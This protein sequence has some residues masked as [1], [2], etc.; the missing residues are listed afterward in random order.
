MVAIII[1]FLIGA[2]LYFSYT[3]TTTTVPVVVPPPTTTQPA[4]PITTTTTTTTTATTTTI[5]PTST[6][7]VLNAAQKQAFLNFGISSSSIPANFSPTQ[8]TCFVTALGAPRVAQIKSGAV[9][10]LTEFAKAKGCFIL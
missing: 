5:A 7:F 3:G 6:P 4:A 1:V 2:G 8:E 9:P 10:T